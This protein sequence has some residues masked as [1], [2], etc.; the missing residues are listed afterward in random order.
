MTKEEIDQMMSEIDHGTDKTGEKCPCND[1]HDERMIEEA[2]QK[3]KGK[4]NKDEIRDFQ[5]SLLKAQKR[6][7]AKEKEKQA[8]NNK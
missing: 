7:L 6:D 5:K 3:V 2:K 4:L 8:N 1:I